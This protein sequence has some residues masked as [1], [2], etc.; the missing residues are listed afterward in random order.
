M[1]TL[2]DLLRSKRRTEEDERICASCGRAVGDSDEVVRASVT[3]GTL[4]FH[5]ACF[6][7]EWGFE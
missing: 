7:V 5:A 6:D 1:K 2:L 3:A 4:W